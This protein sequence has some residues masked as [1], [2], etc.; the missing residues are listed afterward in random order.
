FAKRTIALG[1][2]LLRGGIKNVARG[3]HAE[4]PRGRGKAHHTVCAAAQIEDAEL[5]RITAVIVVH[6]AI[7]EVV[8]GWRPLD[9]MGKRHPMR[10]QL[11][12]MRE[13]T[14]AHLV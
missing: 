6:R 8:P 2:A 14:H 11:P 5:S 12:G 1:G 10:P 3:M 7:K 4:M 9:R 13:V